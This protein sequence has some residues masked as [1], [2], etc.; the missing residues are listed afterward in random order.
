MTNFST[1]RHSRFDERTWEGQGKSHEER[2]RL[3]LST[4]REFHLSNT[5]AR[6]ACHEPRW[7][8]VSE[9]GLGASSLQFPFDDHT[10]TCL[11]T[12]IASSV[13]GGSSTP[14]LAKT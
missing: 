5:E 9:A 11:G 13:H 14:N 1:S 6:V 2:L 3:Y 8:T 4:D 7:G 10:D 12:P